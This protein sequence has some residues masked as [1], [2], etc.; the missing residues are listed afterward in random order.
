MRSFDTSRASGATDRHVV[1]TLPANGLYAP[2]GY[3]M[4]PARQTGAS[5]A[6]L[7]A[8]RTIRR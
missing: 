7:M 3:I 5:R 8:L 1:C 6:V 2:M 4:R